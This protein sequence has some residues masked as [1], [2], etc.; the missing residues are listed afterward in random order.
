MLALVGDGQSK[1]SLEEK[2]RTDGIPNVRF[3][4]LQDD[5]P[6]TLAAADILIVNQLNDV[7]DSVAPSKLLAYMAAS[8]P[9]L[10]VVNDRS[11]A[12]HVVRASGGGMVIPPG[13]PELFAAAVH[14]LRGD[15]ALRQQMGLSGRKWVQSHFGK[16]EALTAW[17]AALA[18]MLRH[19]D[20]VA[21]R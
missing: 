14:R 7:V 13:E 8:R 6:S 12:A 10:A 16:Q 18:K 21:T 20:P 17:D 1:R 11:E 5:F 19:R 9:V 3:V 2:V 4:P 15:G